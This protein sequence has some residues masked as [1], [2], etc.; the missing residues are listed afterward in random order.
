MV[1]LFDISI[2]VIEEFVALLFISL[3]LGYKYDG[4]KKNIG[5]VVTLVVS[6]IIM[7]YLNSL[8]IYE[9]FLGMIFTAIYFIYS[10]MFLKGDIY[11]KL[12]IAQFTN[13]IAYFIAIISTLGV[14]V[15]TSIP[16]EK[17]YAVGAV[18]IGLSIFS[19]VLLVLV[20]ML[21]LKFKTKSMR[22]NTYMKILVF[23]PVV[24]ESAMTGIM[25]VFVADG[26]INNDLLLS[27]ISVMLA[28]VL[29]F[30]AFIKISRDMKKEAEMQIQQQKYENDKRFAVEVEELYSKTCG[31]R[32]DILNHIEII[33]GLIRTDKEK[34]LEYIESV[35]HNQLGQMKYFIKTDNDCFDAIA[36]AKLAVCEKLN[37]KVQVRVMN[38]TL[39][40]LKND[41]IGVIFGNL[42]DNAIDATKNSKEKRI[43]VDIQQQGKRCSIIM[44]NS[45]DESVLQNN[46][47]LE[48]TKQDKEF[49]GLGLKN[50]QR[51]VDNY[52]GM[53]NFFE[54]NSFF[55][56]DIL[57]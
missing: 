53:I 23:L 49:H 45:I 3:Y 34:A 22:Y 35:T 7:E 26:G 31:L 40:R 15:L 38:N 32:H 54:E 18:K 47:E 21:L 12:F 43:E 33:A 37:I 25:N 36:N 55:S 6:V 28:N 2:S 29:T 17:L 24:T 4:H 9:G 14:S 44:Q 10:L 48:T 16:N 50:I 39:N 56:C 1:D 52:G 19:K 46:A 42:F 8:Y 13:C 20:F 41:E 11:T 57:I 51:I 30:Y 27:T 5:F